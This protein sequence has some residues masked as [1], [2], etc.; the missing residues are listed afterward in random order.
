MNLLLIAVTK[1]SQITTNMSAFIYKKRSSHKNKCVFSS[2]K[3]CHVSETRITFYNTWHKQCHQKRKLR[4]NNFSPLLSHLSL[5]SSF[6]IKSCQILCSEMRDLG[7][8]FRVD[9]NYRN[10]YDRSSKTTGPEAFVE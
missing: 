10:K 2:H 8:W 7:E 9:T 3:G 5:I 6:I 4:I 1:V